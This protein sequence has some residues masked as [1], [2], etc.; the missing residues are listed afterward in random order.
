MKTEISIRTLGMYLGA[1]YYDI[2]YPDEGVNA[3]GHDQLAQYIVDG[4]TKNVVLLLKSQY[5]ALSEIEAGDVRAVVGKLSHRAAAD[6]AALDFA[7]TIGRDMG[8]FVLRDGKEEWVSSLIDAGV[9][10]EINSNT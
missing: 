6:A 7:R 3:F 8:G 5:T 4:N 10:T 9:A 1:D 2:E